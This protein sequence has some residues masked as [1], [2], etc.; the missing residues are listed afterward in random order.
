VLLSGPRAFARRAAARP[1]GGLYIAFGGGSPADPDLTP[2]ARRFVRE[3]GARRGED[4]VLEAAQATETVLTAIARSD[5]TRASVLD[6]LRAA[7]EQNGILGDFAF[8]R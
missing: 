1:A 6:G 7:R 5:G 8:D 2:A 3:F 4:G